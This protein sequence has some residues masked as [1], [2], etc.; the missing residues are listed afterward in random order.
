MR[1]KRIVYSLLTFVVMFLAMLALW[2][3]SGSSSHVVAET[4]EGGQ[5]A[6]GQIQQAFSPRVEWHKGD[7]SASMSFLRPEGVEMAFSKW[8][9]LHEDDSTTCGDQPLNN[10]LYVHY[11]DQVHYCYK[12]TNIG[13]TNLYTHTLVDDQ[14]DK[15]I[16]EDQE[17]EMLPNGHFLIDSGASLS[18]TQEIT[19]NAY[20]E[21]HTIDG[22]AYRKFSSATVKVLI[23]F[24][25]HVYQGAVGVNDTP[26]GSVTLQLYGWNEG[27]AMPET[28]LQEVTSADDGFF[29]V[30]EGE[31]LDYYRLL[32]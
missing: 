4:I 22:T 26:L 14:F 30:L 23:R 16:F 21:A 13:D 32:K 31:T 8:A 20:W 2:S 19:N 17:F 28:P 6:S 11:G 7:R 1:I 15:P 10:I 3:F 25:G 12:A 5:A 24:R 29:N 27:E 18:I 9:I